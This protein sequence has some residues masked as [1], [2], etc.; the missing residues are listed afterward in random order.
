MVNGA[1]IRVVFPCVQPRSTPAMD[2][3]GQAHNSSSDRQGANP[4][5]HPIGPVAKC[6]S[7]D[8]LGV[9]VKPH[10][11]IGCTRMGWF[12]TKIFN[13]KYLFCAGRHVAA[14]GDAVAA[15]H[16]DRTHKPGSVQALCQNQWQAR[17]WIF[18]R[19]AAVCIPEIPSAGLP[20]LLWFMLLLSSSTTT[21]VDSN[22]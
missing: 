6:K 21:Q 16:C 5:E 3:A 9:S 15:E 11:A 22:L 17:S 20:R 14:P 8:S 1:L 18:S 19:I 2:A 4:F 7:G 13:L 12:T 10:Q